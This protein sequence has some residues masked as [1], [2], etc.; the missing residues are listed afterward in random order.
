[1]GG[2]KEQ[3][4]ASASNRYAPESQIDWLDGGAKE[5]KDQLHNFLERT[6]KQNA[7]VLAELLSSSTGYESFE[8][9]VDRERFL[10]DFWTATIHVPDPPSAIF[11]CEAQPSDETSK[12][13]LEEIARK[14]A[15][16]TT[17]NRRLQPAGYT[18]LGQFITHDLVSST[19]LINERIATPALNLDSLYFDESISD[20]AQLV[21]W[22]A[23]TAEGFFSFSDDFDLKRETWS[24]E[25]LKEGD[26]PVPTEGLDYH[27]AIIPEHRNDGNI[28]LSQLHL[29]WQ[30][31]HNYFARKVKKKNTNYS[32]QKVYSL[33][34]KLT[35]LIFQHVVVEDYL[36]RTID[37]DVYQYYFLDDRE[38]QLLDLKSELTIPHEFSHAV[39]RYGHA[40][41]RENYILKDSNV[42]LGALFAKNQY[43]GEALAKAENKKLDPNENLI[44]WQLFFDPIRTSDDGNRANTISVRSVQGLH[45]VQGNVDDKR[46]VRLIM[47]DLNASKSLATYGEILRCGKLN[48]LL[49][50]IKDIRLPEQYFNRISFEYFEDIAKGPTPNLDNCPFWLTQLLESEIAPSSDAGES[51]RKGNGDKMG[52]VASVVMAE[53]I[54]ACVLNAE[55]SIYKLNEFF[56]SHKQDASEIYRSFVTT[57]RHLKIKNLI[58]LI[59]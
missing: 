14:I 16:R 58:P 10:R 12:L 43:A 33:A 27:I 47:A 21:K 8:D 42:Q 36:L 24:S 22:N 26:I 51:I 30:K 31:V 19:N 49:E 37:P 32:G 40:M 46:L 9:G 34:K 25:E 59:K 41:V 39:S 2:E 50:D 18:Y 48:R 54:K 45:C 23:I 29:F 3:K 13:P 4:L 35:T 55:T 28:I 20:F 7:D 5:R 53:T 6:N 57:H 1:M 38:L 44:D 15:K 52:F 56:E 17:A 11:T